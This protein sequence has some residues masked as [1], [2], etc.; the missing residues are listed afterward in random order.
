MIKHFLALKLLANLLTTGVNQEGRE[1]SDV[2]VFKHLFVL[3][4]V[5]LVEEDIRIGRIITLI[6]L[7]HHLERFSD[8]LAWLALFVPEFENNRLA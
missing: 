2:H 1:L 3:C 4:F 8:L 7:H 6:I 5:D